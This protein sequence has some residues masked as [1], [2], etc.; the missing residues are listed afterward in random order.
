MSTSALNLCLKL[1][2]CYSTIFTKKPSLLSLQWA[3]FVT[4]QSFLHLSIPFAITSQNHTCVSTFSIS[5]KWPKSSL[6]SIAL[7]IWFSI[8]QHFDLD[9]TSLANRHNH[10]TLIQSP[11]TISQV[12][13]YRFLNI[14]A[15]PVSTSPSSPRKLTSKR[16][17]F[18]KIE[19]T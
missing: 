19:L 8:L 3:R 13:A 6:A 7:K 15:R 17:T 5:M 1:L 2:H 4:S 9:L 10:R 16:I 11:I 12:Q 18:F 14:G